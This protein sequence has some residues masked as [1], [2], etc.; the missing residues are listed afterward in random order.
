MT[1]V[2]EARPV[3]PA[4]RRR[5]R[6]ELAEQLIIEYAG[7]VPPG[8]VLATVLRADRVLRRNGA[9]SAGNEEL[10]ESLVRHQLADY[11][12]RGSTRPRVCR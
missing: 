1:L 12:A 10:F 4:E 8:R 11:A 7:A 2:D 3:A 9:A 6:L 5:R